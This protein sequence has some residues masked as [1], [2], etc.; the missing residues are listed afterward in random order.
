M[1]AERR[2]KGKQK[3]NNWD[4]MVANLKAKFMPKD[5]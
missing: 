1:Q 5:Y 2:S 4:R 3:I